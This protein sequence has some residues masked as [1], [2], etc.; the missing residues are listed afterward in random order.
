MLEPVESDSHSDSDASG[1]GGDGGGLMSSMAD[2]YG[3]QD[4]SPTDTG[5]LRSSLLFN[6]QLSPPS[7][8]RYRTD[9]ANFHRGSFCSPEDPAKG[10]RIDSGG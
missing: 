1:D 7:S 9:L 2:F 6:L 4:S 8:N 3:I 10:S 5:T